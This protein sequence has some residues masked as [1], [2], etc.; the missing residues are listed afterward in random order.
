DHQRPGEMSAAINLGWDPRPHYMW[1]LSQ[2]TVL[3]RKIIDTPQYTYVFEYDGKND[4]SYYEFAFISYL[5]DKLGYDNLAV[6]H[7]YRDATLAETERKQNF[8]KDQENN[9]TPEE[10]QWPPNK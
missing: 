8:G 5:K 10:I 7:T 4:K 3:N 6:C 2:P 1:C 9:R